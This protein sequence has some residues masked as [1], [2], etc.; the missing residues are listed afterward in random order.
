MKLYKYKE[1]K[2]KQH[3]NVQI[4]YFKIVLRPNNKNK[5]RRVEKRA[6]DNTKKLNME[7]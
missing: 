2:R 1:E 4:I 7:N 5:E 6:S 3:I